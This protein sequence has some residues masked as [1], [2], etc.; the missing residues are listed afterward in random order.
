MK[1]LGKCVHGSRLYGLENEQSDFD[2]KSIHLPSVTDCL[3]LKATQTENTKVEEKNEEYESFALQKFLH[4]CTSAQ[5]CVIAMLHAPKSRVIIDSEIYEALRVHRDK[6]YTKSMKGSLGYAKGQ[7]VK[8]ALRAD[9]MNAVK[10]FLD[11]LRN[12]EKNGVARLYQIYDD[13]PDGPYYFKGIEERNNTVDKRYFECA[14][15]KL[16]ATVA[17]SYALEIFENLYNQYGDRVKIA[18]SLDAHDYKSISHAF[19]CGYQLRAIYEDGGFEY[20]LRETKF[21]KDV[22]FGKISYIDG[23]LDAKLNDLITHVEELSEKSNLP[24]KVDQKWVDN[25][26]LATYGY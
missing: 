3:L 24:A 12:A 9:R 16:T 25:L 6:F 2:Y 4:L 19:R 14:G 17:I 8:Y 11:I 18:A 7:S 26:I 20:P 22:K 5:D 1:I 23:N 15:K 21:I 13:L 10:A